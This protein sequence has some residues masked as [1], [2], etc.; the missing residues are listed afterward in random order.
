MGGNQSGHGVFF[1]RL[2]IA[3]LP[4]YLE[5]L[6][7]NHPFINTSPFPE[8]SSPRLAYTAI[9]A[10]HINKHC[11]LLLVRAAVSLLNPDW[12]LPAL[13]YTMLLFPN[14]REYERSTPWPERS[15]IHIQ[16]KPD[17]ALTVC[18]GRHFFALCF[19]H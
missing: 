10:S 3:S 11:L 19:T 6:F 5:L 13:I 9:A 18:F 17:L 14:L 12:A 8:S 4:P 16:L 15:S 7:Q 1:V 2:A